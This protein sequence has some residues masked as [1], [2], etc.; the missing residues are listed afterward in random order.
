MH[1]KQAILVDEDTIVNVATGDRYRVD[2]AASCRTHRLASRSE[3]V[4][5][6]WIRHERERRGY[7]EQW[8]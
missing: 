4:G 3:R 6:A 8:R 7:R 2:T 5:T 1:R